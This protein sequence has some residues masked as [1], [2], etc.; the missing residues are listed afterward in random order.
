MAG[1]AAILII[2]LIIAAVFL[3]TVL[4]K[5][6][7][8]SKNN[9][10]GFLINQSGRGSAGTT[11]YAVDGNFSLPLTIEP[12]DDCML[13]ALV[14]YQAVPF[15]FNGSYGKTHYLNGS[16]AN[17]YN[18]TFRVT[19]LSQGYHDVILAGFV[20]PCNFT[21]DASR[22]INRMTTGALMYNVIVDNGTKPMPVFENSS[23]A[24]NATYRLDYDFGGPNIFREPFDNRGWSREDVKPGQVLDYY[25]QV[26]HG[27]I[28]GKKLNTSYAIVQLLDYN[29]IPVRFNAY[30]YVYYGYIT[31]NESSSVH[32]SLKAPDTAGPHRL[33]VLLATD[34]FEDREIA[35]GV[36]NT[37][38]TRSFQAEYIDLFVKE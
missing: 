18:G 32:L 30:D 16:P 37:N 6:F 17:Q 5:N 21:Y 28:N 11:Q 8:Q 25:L 33:V 4:L 26:G 24:G 38:I 20:V 2:V 14:D 3:V 34:P 31:V 9:S 29:Q 27:L 7:T 1:I 35:P 36:M 13:V 22:Q 10:I 15:Y 12:S 19:N 23:T